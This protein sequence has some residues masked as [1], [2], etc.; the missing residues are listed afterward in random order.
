[1]NTN[2]DKI[3]NT[4]PLLN[5]ISIVLCKGLNELFK[6][7]LLEHQLYK[8]THLGVLKLINNNNRFSNQEESKEEKS[9]S[10][11]FKELEYNFDKK[12]EALVHLMNASILDLKHMVQKNNNEIDLL[13]N[14]L[15][16]DNNIDLIEEKE[17]IILKIEPIEKQHS[18]KNEVVKVEKKEVV[19]MFDESNNINWTDVK[20]EE[21][22]EQVQEVKEEEE[23]QEE[24]EEK[25]EEEEED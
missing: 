12:L 10:N 13:K 25:D 6:D 14:H 8:Q 21:E 4:D 24:E 16:R 23:E 15:K 7:F 20:E 3:F 1:M 22:E 11:Q 18:F 17:N 9:L 2:N 5:D 19:Y